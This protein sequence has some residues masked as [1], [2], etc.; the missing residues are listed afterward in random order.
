MNL[1]SLSA[2]DRRIAGAAA[3]AAIMAL[4]NVSWG[5]TVPLALIAAI[6]AIGVVLWPQL[7]PNSPL[8]A[9]RGLLLVALG[10]IT[11]GGYVIAGLMWL[12][13][14]FEITNIYT[15]LFDIGLIASLALLWLGWMAYQGETK[16]AAPGSAESAPPPPPAAGS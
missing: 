10:A 13:D 4:V 1:S 15:I 3:I 8:P 7:A 14:V 11:A 6:L 9:P 12:E 2:G 5:P 16:V